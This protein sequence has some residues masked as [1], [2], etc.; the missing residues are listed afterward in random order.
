MKVVIRIIE[1][2]ES[3]IIKNLICFSLLYSLIQNYHFLD[4]KMSLIIPTSYYFE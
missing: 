3:I 4:I 1:L 2:F